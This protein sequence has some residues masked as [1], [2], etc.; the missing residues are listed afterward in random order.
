MYT[1]KDLYEQ[2]KAMSAPTDSIIHMHTSLRAVGEFEG[3]GEGLLEGMIEYFTHDGGL[4]TVPTHT[5]SKG[6]LDLSDH[7]TCIGTFPT[8]AASHPEAVR[9]LHPTHSMVA[10]GDDDKVREFISHD[11]MT[12]TST[13]PDGCY[14]EL[15][16]RNGCILLVGVPHDNNT[17]MHCVEEMLD[18]PGRLTFNRQ[19]T[20]VKL[21]NGQVIDRPIRRHL[22]NVSKYFHKYEPAFRYHGAVTDGFVGSAKTQLCSCVK[23][24]EV[25]ELV[26]NRSGGI[27]LLADD[28]P[29]KEK[30]YK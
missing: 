30:W 29:L 17:Y 9:S 7:E 24:K 4:F 1:K 23:I 16:R 20:T 11:N 6:Y 15:Y 5:W 28:E 3:R 14:G 13:H 27:N 18:I 26:F 21:E 8:L 19:N 25:M 10:F 2:L 12:S 22:G